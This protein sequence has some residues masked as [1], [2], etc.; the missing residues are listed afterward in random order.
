MMH[1]AV[2]LDGPLSSGCF[3]GGGGNG[4]KSKDSK[5]K[6]TM[7]MGLNPPSYLSVFFFSISINALMEGSIS[8]ILVDSRSAL[9]E[10]RVW[11]EMPD[12]SCRAAK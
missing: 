3:G 7:K 10:S 4:E 12:P 11:L 2:P 5:M 6:M 8:S 1:S 9:N